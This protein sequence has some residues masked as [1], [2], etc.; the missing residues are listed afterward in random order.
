[1]EKLFAHRVEVAPVRC[2]SRRDRAF[3]LRI[4]RLRRISLTVMVR[5]SSKPTPGL[6]SNRCGRVCGCEGRRVLRCRSDC[7]CRP[8]SLPRCANDNNTRLQSCC[9]CFPNRGFDLQR[10][11][12]PASKLECRSRC[13]TTPS[14]TILTWLPRAQAS[15][16][17]AQHLDLIGTISHINRPLDISGNGAALSSRVAGGSLRK[18]RGCYRRSFQSCRKRRY[19]T[20]VIQPSLLPNV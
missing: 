12:Q 19:A 15:A 3:A 4:D 7:M 13:C 2:P 8:E 5:P 10:L 6:T 11:Q 17:S 16:D 1:M 9:E 18:F 20:P 14:T